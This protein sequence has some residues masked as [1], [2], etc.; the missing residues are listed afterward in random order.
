MLI[1]PTPTGRSHVAAG[2]GTRA[3]VQSAPMSTNAHQTLIIVIV[4]PLAWT[5]LVHSNVLAISDI[6]AMA[7]RVLAQMTN[8]QRGHTIVTFVPPALTQGCRSCVTVIPVGLAMV[9]HAL[10]STSVRLI[11][12]IAR[13]RRTVPIFQDRLAALVNSD[14][15]E[16]GL[17]VTMLTNAAVIHTTATLMQF[18]QTP[19]GRLPAHV[20]LDTPELVSDVI[21]S[22]NVAWA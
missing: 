14:S 21:P 4:L 16:M 17:F 12:T 10:I 5:L 19:L 2:L 6:P 7:L 8:A 3:V 22:M 20:S 13:H 1:A 15:L 11:F 18:A 9:L